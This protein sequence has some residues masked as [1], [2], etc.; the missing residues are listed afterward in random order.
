M[1][2]GAGPGYGRMIVRLYVWSAPVIEH[3][4][5][6][7]DVTFHEG[8]TVIHTTTANQ[9]FSVQNLNLYVDLA[10]FLA[11]LL[12]LPGLGWRARLRMGFLGYLPLGVAHFTAFALAVRMA[13]VQLDLK[14]KG[15]TPG[16]VSLYLA[17][18]LRKILY[19]DLIL[20]FPFL[21]CGALF[22]LEKGGRRRG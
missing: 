4:L 9:K 15:I 14:T 3:P 1:W 13:N 21:I 17:S 22:L 20:L 18:P 6:T 16:F 12:C 19:S 11:L 10:I 2:L 5:R 8:R 7:S